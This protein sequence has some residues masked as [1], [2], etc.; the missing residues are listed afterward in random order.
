MWAEIYVPGD[1][2]AH[3][4]I[5]RLLYG[6]NGDVSVPPAGGAALQ[7]TR[8]H[9]CTW[10]NW[11]P[12]EIHQNVGHGDVILLYFCSETFV[13]LTVCAPQAEFFI[14]FLTK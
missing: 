2:R 14:I 6:V 12:N 9:T 1:E 8:S 11:P 4:E 10:K 7:S 3:S 13:R 5:W